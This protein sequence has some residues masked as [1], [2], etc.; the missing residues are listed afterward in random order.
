MR[1]RV[2]RDSCRRIPRRGFQLLTPLQS[3]LLDQEV[4][5]P[6]LTVP[7]GAGCVSPI[8]RI[9]SPWADRGGSV[10]SASV[11]GPGSTKL[12]IAGPF[13]GRLIIL[14]PIV[15]PWAN[16]GSAVCSASVR[17]EPDQIGSGFGA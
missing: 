9:V 10:R 2:A 11:Y 1:L 17:P 5:L 14:D 16:K 12:A 3:S 13:P 8:V 4:R 6:E 15:E 7:S